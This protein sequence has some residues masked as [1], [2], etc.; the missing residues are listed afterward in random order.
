MPTLQI[1]LPAEALA[2]FCRKWQI[3]RLEVFGSALRDDFRPDSDIDFLAT[4][5]PE[6][7][8]SLFDHVTMEDE[9]KTLL[10][11]DVDL[12]SRRTVEQSHNPYRQKS[13][14]DSA[15]AIYPAS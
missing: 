12:V 7:R 2:T 4:F 1:D 13:T 6:S 10:G 14:L 15:C 8:W 5:A 3:V 9:L 11:R